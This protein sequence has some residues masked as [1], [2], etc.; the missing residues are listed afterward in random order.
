[1]NIH[2]QK[3]LEIP[4]WTIAQIPNDISFP[5]PN[6]IT[7]TQIDLPAGTNELGSS[8]GLLLVAIVAGCA[9]ARIWNK[10]NRTTGTLTRGALF[11]TSPNEF[12]CVEL[13]RSCRA[14]TLSFDWGSQT[15]DIPNWE[16]IGTQ[17]FRDI[18]IF[19]TC[20]RFYE[21]HISSIDISISLM[22][23]AA[24]LIFNAL[25]IQ[26][27]RAKFA[28]PVANATKQE[29]LRKSVTW[30]EDNLGER[31]TLKQLSLIAGISEWYFVREF[32]SCFARSPYQF[33][34]ERRL[35]KA[36]RLLRES[37]LTIC[38]IAYDCG[39]SSQSH[40]TTTFKQRLG[41]TPKV[42][43]NCQEAMS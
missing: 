39:F 12:S 28:F 37:T 7:T 32:K 30:I 19:E 21:E 9:E 42:Y 29:K 16:K 38:Q 27:Q 8:N 35:A 1:M 36:Q 33:V 23:S 4:S 25:Q 10:T 20:S 22:E 18:L 31:I 43:R 40:M 2:I 34:L 26:D 13:D 24:F 41:V 11:L 15:S 14:V 3:K 17:I 6:S 5:L